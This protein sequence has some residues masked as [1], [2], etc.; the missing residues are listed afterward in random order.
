MEHWQIQI[1]PISLACA[2][3]LQVFILGGQLWKGKYN[4][5]KNP[6]NKQI[7]S[8]QS[9]GLHKKG[10]VSFK[11]KKKVTCVYQKGES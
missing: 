8:L 11:T 7:R 4:F 9:Q 5:L 3:I 2:M 1:I 6:S 10:R